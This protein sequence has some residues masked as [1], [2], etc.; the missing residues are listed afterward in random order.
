M[1]ALARVGKEERGEA[2]LLGTVLEN[3]S[4]QA[5]HAHATTL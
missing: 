5:A 4:K 1:A 2:R 3:Q